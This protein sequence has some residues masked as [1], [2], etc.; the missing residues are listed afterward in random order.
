M[1]FTQ[2]DNYIYVASREILI[3][4][5]RKDIVVFKY[6]FDF[7]L[8]KSKVMHLYVFKIFYFIYFYFRSTFIVGCTSPLLIFGIKKK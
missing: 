4:F 1:D 8:L 3:K 5:K 7:C 2:D 6:K